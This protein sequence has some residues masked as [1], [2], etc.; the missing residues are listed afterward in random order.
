VAVLATVV[1]S[2]AALIIPAAASAAP[3]NNYS[4]GFETDTNGWCDQPAYGPC[5]GVSNG[6]ITRTMSGSAAAYA[7]GISAA[8]GNWYARVT[9]APDP[10]DSACTPAD[11]SAGECFGPY[12]D[13][14]AG[15]NASTFPTNGFTT[16]LD[17][18][19]DTSFAV[20]HPDIRFDWDTAMNDNNGNFLQDYAFNAGTSPVGSPEWFV[21]AATNAGRGSSFPENT[22]PSP[23]SP[24]NSCRAFAVISSS[25]WYRFAHRFYAASD[26]DLA[27]E[28]SIVS[29][30][31]GNLVP[32]ADWTIDSG[33]PISGVGGPS[34][35][36]FPNEEISGLPIDN[37]SLT[38]A[39]VPPTSA[40]QCKNG[41][42]RNLT[43]ANGTR[44]KNQGDCVSYVAT[45]G[46]NKAAG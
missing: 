2:C 14:D 33:T 12:T 22:C 20:S 19:L 29:E 36:Y 5:D 37:S 45:G 21:N 44:F 34:A 35:G 39:P 8:S 28:M 31:T 3:L 46:K 16:T 38:V 42:W 7:S 4:N 24:P 9:G 43:D 32:G 27:V 25:G 18:Y 30:T 23:S 6:T 26:G 10:M 17:I 41:G 13:Y 40:D 11:N 1:A 15:T